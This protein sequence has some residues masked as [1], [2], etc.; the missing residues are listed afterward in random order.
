MLTLILAAASLMVISTDSRLPS[1]IQKAVKDW[2]AAPRMEISWQTLLEFCLLQLRSKA[3]LHLETGILRRSKTSCE[4]VYY[5]GTNRYV[6]KF[7]KVRGPGKISQVFDDQNMDVTEKIREYMGPCHNFHGIPTT[8][9][10]LGYDQLRFVLLN[11]EIIT[12]QGEDV[13]KI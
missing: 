11:D 4:L 13:I 10:L 2:K 3:S 12:I 7:P 8:P 9:K 1:R 6:V 5:E